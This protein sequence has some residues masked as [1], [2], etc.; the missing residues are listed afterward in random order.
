[1]TRLNLAL[2]LALLTSSLYLVSVQ[3]ES[4]RLFSELDKAHSQAHRLEADKERLQ[5]QMRS[6]GTPLRIERL[7]KEKLQMRSAT[8]AITH[9]VSYNTEPPLDSGRV[10]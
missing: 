2:L 5:V 3:Y 8:P 10:Q 9:Y 4:R 1:M 6:L 7:A